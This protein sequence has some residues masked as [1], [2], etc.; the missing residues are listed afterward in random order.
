MIV[1]EQYLPLLGNRKCRPS[2]DLNHTVFLQCLIYHYLLHPGKWAET[3]GAKS[4]GMIILS[5]SKTMTLHSQALTINYLIK[6][7]INSITQK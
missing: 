1:Q 3:Q 2:M 6:Q 5:R 7:D 4:F